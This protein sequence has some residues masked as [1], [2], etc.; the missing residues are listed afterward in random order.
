MARGAMLPSSM[1]C[2][3]IANVNRDPKRSSRT[4]TPAYFNPY[5]PQA[6]TKPVISRKNK[7][8]HL[9]KDIFIGRG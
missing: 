6:A 2:S 9:L 5:M 1:V 8:F 7:N 4:Y 3:L